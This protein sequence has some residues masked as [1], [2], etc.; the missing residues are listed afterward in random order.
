MNFLL[1]SKYVLVWTGTTCGAVV[2]ESAQHMI[3]VLDDTYPNA[4]DP[5]RCHLLNPAN[6]ECCPED[7]PFCCQYKHTDE[8]ED[9]TVTAVRVMELV[10]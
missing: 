10:S 3:D 7:A 6:W 1:Q 4:G 9:Y 2:C 8:F 5:V